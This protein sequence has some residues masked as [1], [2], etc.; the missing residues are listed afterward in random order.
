MSVG[1]GRIAAVSKSNQG[2]ILSGFVS[3]IEWARFSRSGEKTK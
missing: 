2:R 3:K 1:T